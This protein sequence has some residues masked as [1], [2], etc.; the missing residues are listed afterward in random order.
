[1]SKKS[2]NSEFELGLLGHDESAFVKV[3]GYSAFEHT[4]VLIVY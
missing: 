1:M 4:V 3:E 2:K